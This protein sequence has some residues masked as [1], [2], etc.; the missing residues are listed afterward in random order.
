MNQVPFVFGAAFMVVGQIRS[1]RNRV[2]SLREALLGV[3][4]STGEQFFGAW[5]AAGERAHAAERDARTSECTA[6]V[7]GLEPQPQAER[8]TLVH[9]KFH[10]GGAVIG[11]STRNHDFRQDFARHQIIGVSPRNELLDRDF[12]DAARPLDCHRGSQNQ[13]QRRRIGMRLGETKISS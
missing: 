4:E 8:G 6:A 7:R 12:A 9:L 3:D 11:S 5:R 1:I 10:V 13:K 2:R